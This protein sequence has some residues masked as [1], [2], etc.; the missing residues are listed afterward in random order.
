MDA[1]QPRVIA[2]K[3]QI[4]EEKK[5]ISDDRQE[6]INF[7]AFQFIVGEALP[8]ST[9]ESVYFRNLLKEIDPRVNVLCV[10]SLEVT[11]A[12][13][14]VKFK[15]NLKKEFRSA[16]QV[17]LTADIWGANNRS[18]LGVTAHWLVLNEADHSIERKSAA[19][20]CKRFPG[21]Y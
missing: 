1:L 8:L 15:D 21:D 6:T 19:V 14:F 7:R 2:H 10:K 12:K 4:L 17:C 5:K 3:K 20:A 11:I 9:V 18:F 16:S 13:E